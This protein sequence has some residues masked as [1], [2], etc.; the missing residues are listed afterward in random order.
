MQIGGIYV[1]SQNHA[2]HLFIVSRAGTL[3]LGT[4]DLPC[5]VGREAELF[6]LARLMRWDS[7]CPDMEIMTRRKLVYLACEVA[8]N[9]IRRL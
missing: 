3:D 7:T 2:T 5:P 4:N 9:S 1:N 8:S 6:C